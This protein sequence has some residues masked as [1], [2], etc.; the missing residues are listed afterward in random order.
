MF[1]V[2]HVYAS[3]GFPVNNISHRPPLLV[4]Q[5][6]DPRDQPGTE[7]FHLLQDGR[8]VQLRQTRGPLLDIDRPSVESQVRLEITLW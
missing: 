5:Y 3:I 6:L 1:V 4:F 2:D 8:T 7:P